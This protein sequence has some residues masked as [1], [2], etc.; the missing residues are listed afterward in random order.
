MDLDQ[1]QRRAWVSG[2]LIALLALLGLVMAFLQYRWTG[3]L[4]R[5]EEARLKEALQQ[6]LNRL[7]AGLDAELSATLGQ[8][9]PTPAEVADL[10]R[11]AAYA[12]RFRHNPHAKVFRELAIAIPNDGQLTLKRWTPEQGFAASEWPVAWTLLRDQL[13]SRMRG[14]R[15]RP[16]EPNEFLLEIPRFGRPPVPGGLAEQDWLI[17]ELDPAYLRDVFLARQIAR[18]LGP[19]SYQVEVYAS[20]AAGTPLLRLGLPEGATLRRNALASVR[21]FERQR[22][23]MRPPFAGGK[24]GRPDPG[25]AGWQ[26]YASLPGGSL[27]DLVDRTRWRN[28]AMALTLLLLI[29]ATAL[30]LVRS[31][32]QAQQLAELQMNFVSGV[33]HELRTPLTVIRT[34][35]FNLRGAVA[36]KPE[37]VERY[38]KLIQ[39]QSEK[40]GALV[41]Q[42]L[43]YA[44]TRAGQVIQE[45]EAVLIDDVIE[46][47]IASSQLALDASPYQLEKDI[48]ADLPLVLADERALQHVVRN[49]LD[50]AVKYGTETS[51][52]IGL[53]ARQDADVVEIRVADRGPGIPAEER[54][55]VF[56]PFFRGRRALADQVQGTG[57]GLSLVK[58]IVEAHGGSIEVRQH[59]PQGSE[60][61]VRIPVAPPEMQDE[62]AHTAG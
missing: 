19:G 4:S 28:L 38:G 55:L 13:T 10:G 6:S 35:A 58:K 51:N 22:P 16:G 41:E 37:Q 42:V 57:L 59:I 52:W 50:N 8:L 43:R 47:G 26:L 2:G 17:L 54:A 62:F 9:Q 49:L 21:L 39:E 24:R 46:G 53:T 48:P 45:R 56:D 18:H 15:L 33:S 60:F 30:L 34:A 25:S 3:E 14:E 5:A 31:A 40:L 32:R 61:V 12:A 29:V 20:D 23:E 7:S 44:S 11:E 36:A 27:G 1:M